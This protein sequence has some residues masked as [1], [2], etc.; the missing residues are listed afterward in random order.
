MKKNDLA[1]RLDEFLTAVRSEDELT[2]RTLDK[3]RRDIQKLID[4][5]DPADELTKAKMLDYRDYLVAAGYE[6]SSINS[7]VVVANKYLCWLGSPDLCVGQLKIQST[8][9]DD[10]I[11]PVDYERLLRRASLLAKQVE[12]KNQEIKTSKKKRKKIVNHAETYMA[13]KI[14]GNTGIRISELRYF[15]VENLE[16][17]TNHNKA[18]RVTNKGKTRD[19]P[20]R[21]ELFRE[22]K[23]YCRKNKIKSG[24]IIYNPDTG[25]MYADSTIW[26]RIQKLAGMAKVSLD[27]AHPHAF[28]HMFAKQYLAAG[29]NY[30]DLKTILGHSKL[31]TTQIYAQSTLLEQRRAIERIKY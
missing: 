30:F 16:R 2:K 1:E 28:R 5:L 12:K 17:C 6:K 18:I 13:M 26:R 22:M 8:S 24:P 4:Y 19:V 10:A 7:F 21:Q 9:F 27:S 23:A 29:G 25:K 20:I 14:F 3:Y 15:T 11:S 31:D